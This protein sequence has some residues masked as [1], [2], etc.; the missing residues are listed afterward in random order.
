MERDLLVD[1]GLNR[2]IT[3]KWNFKNCDR[4]GRDWIDLP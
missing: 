3:L 2:N 1:L 4:V